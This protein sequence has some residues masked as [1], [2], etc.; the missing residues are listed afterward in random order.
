MASE[1][2]EPVNEAELEWQNKFAFDP[3]EVISIYKRKE[4]YNTSRQT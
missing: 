1:S 2:E 4:R 3:H